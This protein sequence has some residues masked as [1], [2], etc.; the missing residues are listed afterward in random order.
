MPFS[1]A[2]YCF[3][4]YF[5]ILILNIF[6]THRLFG[7]EYHFRI[8]LHLSLDHF[9]IAVTGILHQTLIVL[10]GFDLSFYNI[11]IE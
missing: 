7:L 2:F 9:T 8:D 6:V 1:V 5:R 4:D 11:G 3:C 10:F